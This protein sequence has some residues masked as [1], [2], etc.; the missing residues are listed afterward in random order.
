[1]AAAHFDLSIRGRQ[2]RG[3]DRSLFARF[4]L[5]LSMGFWNQVWAGSLPSRLVRDRTNRMLGSGTSGFAINLN[6][7]DHLPRNY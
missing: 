4:R 2:H 7:Q 1:M 6:L 3:C 5:P